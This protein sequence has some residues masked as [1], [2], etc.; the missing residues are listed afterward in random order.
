VL[1]LPFSFDPATQE[2][3]PSICAGSLSHPTANKIYIIKRGEKFPPLKYDADLPPAMLV[4]T[5]WR[6]DGDMLQPRKQ[7]KVTKVRTPT[8][9]QIR[10]ESSFSG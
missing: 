5:D 3:K 7:P 6:R 9:S 1:L 10:Y 4:D 8:W 2:P